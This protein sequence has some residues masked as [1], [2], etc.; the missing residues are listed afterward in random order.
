MEIL[1]ERIIEI[2]KTVKDEEK[3]RIVYRFISR[4]LSQE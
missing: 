1:Q 2:I 3:L 4:Y